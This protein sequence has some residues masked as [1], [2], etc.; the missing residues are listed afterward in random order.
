MFPRVRAAQRPWNDANNQE[1]A[2]ENE[3]TLNEGIAG[4]GLLISEAHRGAGVV[5]TEFTAVR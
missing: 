2:A 5:A 4:K 1:G 3:I